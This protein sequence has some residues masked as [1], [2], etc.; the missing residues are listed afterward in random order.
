MNSIRTT[1]DHAT[2]SVSTTSSRS[3]SIANSSFSGRLRFS[4]YNHGTREDRRRSEYPATAE[5]CHCQPTYWDDPPGTIPSRTTSSARLCLGAE[6]PATEGDPNS[7]A[8]PFI[9]DRATSLH[10]GIEPYIKLGRIAV[11]KEFRGLGIAKILANA[12]YDL[13]KGKPLIFNPS[14]A[15]MGLEKMGASSLD[16]LPVWKGLICVHAQEPSDQDMGEMG[17]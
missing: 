4:Q 2:G 15:R 11:V 5:E 9:I 6:A 14:I 17:F 7:S 12:G 16:E 3:D 10:D 13:G 8:P 1:I